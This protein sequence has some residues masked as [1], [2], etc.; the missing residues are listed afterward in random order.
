MNDELPVPLDVIAKQAGFPLALRDQPSTAVPRPRIGIT[1]GQPAEPP[2]VPATGNLARVR[3]TPTTLPSPPSAFEN[4]LRML[5]G[6][7]EPQPLG[8]SGVRG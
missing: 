1:L 3:S 4:L 8:R 6:P 7:E 5:V 2:P